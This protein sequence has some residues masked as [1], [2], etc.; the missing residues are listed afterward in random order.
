MRVVL[1]TVIFVRSLINPYGGCGEI[2]FGY[3]S[4]Y[5]LVLSQPVL[6]EYLEVL[7][8]PELTRKF[9]SLAARSAVDVLEIV[10]TAEAVTLD[11]V[12]AVS[13]DPND[14]IF[15]ATAAACEADY[16]VSE[17]RDLL[18]LRL[19]GRTRI[20]TCLEFLRIL[21]EQFGR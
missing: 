2:V 18:D 16:L 8:R 9:R 10:G 14:D 13:R 21:R 20:V 11:T 12:S 7:A 5:R 1:D 4:R 19:H 15:I 17:D 6:A 3:A